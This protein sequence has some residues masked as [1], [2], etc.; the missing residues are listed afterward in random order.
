MYKLFFI[1]T[2]FLAFQNQASAQN[3]TIWVNGVPKIKKRQPAEEMNPSPVKKDDYLFE[4]SYGY[5]FVPLREANAFGVN[6]LTNTSVYKIVKNTN[7]ICLR[8][9]Y[10]LNDE[11]S[12]GLEFT[13]ANTEFLYKRSYP[14]LI[15]GSNTAV[16]DSSF[17]AQVTKIRFLAKM[18]YHF[19]I[20]ERFDAYGTAGFGYKQFTYSSRDSYLTSQNVLNDILPVAV[21]LSIGGRFFLT[22]TFAIHVEGGVGGPMMQIGASYK[23]H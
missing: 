8:L 11:F 18:G 16:T 5:P 9:D 4:A 3:D 19:N 13:Y 6:Y 20:S 2:F 21:R 12:V 15:T 1:V 23:M 14:P 10:Q 22:N 7:H 17:N